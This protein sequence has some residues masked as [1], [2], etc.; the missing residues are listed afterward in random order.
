MSDSTATL[1]STQTGTGKAL[2]GLLGRVLLTGV[3]FVSVPAH[4][5]PVDLGFAVAAGVPLARLVVPATGI[6]QLIGAIS[7][8]LG[9]R[10]RVGAW[11]LILFLAPV[12]LVMHRF[13]GVSDPMMAALQWGMFT[14]NLS[15]IGGLLL[16][17][18]FGPGAWSLDARRK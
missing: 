15:I 16:L 6:L 10:T 9:Y 1:Q 11:L 2:L 5:G 13:W 14:R 4:F 17:S 3:F 18:Q 7:V 8:L 12:T